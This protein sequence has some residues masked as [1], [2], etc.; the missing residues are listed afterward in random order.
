MMLFAVAFGFC[1]VDAGTK[2][3]AFGFCLVD[4]GT[5][6]VASGFRRVDES[7]LLFSVPGTT[8]GVVYGP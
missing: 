7:P 2:Y 1:R 6:Y 8:G 5:K 4:A 3:V